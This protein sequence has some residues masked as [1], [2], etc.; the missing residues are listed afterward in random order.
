MK[1]ILNDIEHNCFTILTFLLQ[2]YQYIVKW[3]GYNT[4][5]STWEPESNLPTNIIDNYIPDH[6]NEARLRQFV[7]SFERA[8]QFR[9]KGKN[10][11]FTVYVDLDIFRHLFGDRTIVLCDKADFEQLN[12]S[13]NWYYVLDKHGIGK[14]L[15]FPVE[16]SVRLYMKKMYVKR[17]DKLV[18]K[19]KPMERC[20]VY[21]VQV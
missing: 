10:P 8:V 9:L 3:K 19:E 21:A 4:L 7:D 14:M 13:E 2:A 5:D 18:T 12:M 20:M 16:L 1:F 6:I 17:E 15:K 11:T